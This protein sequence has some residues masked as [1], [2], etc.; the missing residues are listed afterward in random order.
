VLGRPSPV[1]TVA[2]AYGWY[3][4]RPPGPTP[5]DDCIAFGD[6]RLSYVGISPTR[7]GSRQNLRKRLRTHLK[8]NASG[9][10]L[11]L[12]LGVLLAQELGLKL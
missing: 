6:S 1:P 9:S 3:F 7:E 8:G 10:T 12:T 2:C 4:R 11:R 5:W